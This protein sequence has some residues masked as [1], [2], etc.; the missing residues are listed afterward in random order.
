M[1]SILQNK[2][3][4]VASSIEI[5]TTWTPSGEAWDGYSPKLRGLESYNVEVR[6]RAIIFGSEVSTSA[7]LGSCWAKP[8]DFDP[9]VHGYFPQMAL[10]AL[11]KLEGKLEMMAHFSER[12][13]VLRQVLA[14]SAAL[15]EEM[16]LLYR[17]QRDEVPQ[18]IRGMS[19]KPAVS[20]Y[21]GQI[22]YSSVFGCREGAEVFPSHAAALTI[23]QGMIFG[24]NGEGFCIEPA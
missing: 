5:T 14:A 1:K 20:Y 12:G 10:E 15:R 13:T 21:H 8:G 7:Y 19:R 24:T 18:V 3:C 9:D 6:A 17:Q 2:L 16:D 4:K 11:E 22:G 23:A